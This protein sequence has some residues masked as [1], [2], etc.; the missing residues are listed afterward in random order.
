M[1]EVENALKGGLIYIRTRTLF[2]STSSSECL[3]YVV[4]ALERNLVLILP[5]IILQ[6]R[7]SAVKNNLERKGD[8]LRKERDRSARVLAC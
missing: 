1:G 4:V 5:L 8:E 2:Q 7:Q 3:L 6:K